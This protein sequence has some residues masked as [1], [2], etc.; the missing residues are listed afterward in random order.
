[1]RSTTEWTVEAG[2]S[3][4]KKVPEGF[5][6]IVVLV[7]WCILL[8]MILPYITEMGSIARTIIG[9][10][11]MLIGFLVIQKIPTGPNS[12]HGLAFTLVFLIAIASFFV[13]IIMVGM[14]IG[15]IT[16]VPQSPV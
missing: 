2:L 4:C 5:K 15:D 11:L 13:G 16:R 1:M 12:I 9:A 7:V 3:Q 6:F 8:W 14:V 10:S